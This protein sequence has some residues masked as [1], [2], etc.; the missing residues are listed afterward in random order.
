MVHKMAAK[1]RH[2]DTYLWAGVHHRHGPVQSIASRSLLC[3]TKS[4]EGCSYFVYTDTQCCSFS[5]LTPLS[6]LSRTETSRDKIIRQGFFAAKGYVALQFNNLWKLIGHRECGLS[7]LTVSASDLGRKS[8]VDLEEHSSW[9]ACL[10]H[11]EYVHLLCTQK[12]SGEG[13][14]SFDLQMIELSKWNDMFQ[15]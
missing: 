10:S 7:N 8:L 15:K 2:A 3:V 11:V 14:G 5:P 12:N 9:T 6:T 13:L 1:N 4:W